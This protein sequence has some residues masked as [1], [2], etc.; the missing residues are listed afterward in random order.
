MLRPESLRGSISQKV[1]FSPESKNNEVGLLEV[2]YYK[3]IITLF[4]LPYS[5]LLDNFSVIFF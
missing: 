1:T 3:K 4:I 2:L 5:Q